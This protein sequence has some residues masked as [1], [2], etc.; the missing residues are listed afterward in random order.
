MNPFKPLK[1]L[2]AW[3]TCVLEVNPQKEDCIPK[4]KKKEKEEGEGTEEE[5]K[6]E[7]EGEGEGWGKR[8]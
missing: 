3:Q 1:E 7:G 6:E 8:R 4:K 2:Y 5:K